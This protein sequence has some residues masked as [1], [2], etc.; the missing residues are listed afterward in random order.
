MNVELLKQS[1]AEKG[2]SGT[3]IAKA[4]G[5]NK[6]TFYRKL[7]RESG[8]FTVEEAAKITEALKLSKKQ[9][10]AIFLDSNWHKCR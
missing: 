10:V 7:K 4:I 5:K 8:S 2:V 9:A 1:M 3:E 6:A